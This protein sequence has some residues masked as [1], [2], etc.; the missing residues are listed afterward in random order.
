MDDTPLCVTLCAPPVHVCVCV[1][2]CV[3]AR[4]RYL[5]TVGR[6]LRCP[7]GDGDG[8]WLTAGITQTVGVL[9]GLPGDRHTVQV[10]QHAHTLF[11]VYAVV[12][13]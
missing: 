2:L 13:H 1:R 9:A 5:V 8:V 11:S 7:G 12:C 3:R 10:S 6:V 4:V